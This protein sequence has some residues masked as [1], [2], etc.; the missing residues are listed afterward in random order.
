MDVTL[1][2]VLLTLE[3]YVSRPGT[4]VSND[5]IYATQEAGLSS[6][7]GLEDCISLVDQQ[8]RDLG[9]PQ[10]IQYDRLHSLDGLIVT[11]A[12]VRDPTSERTP[13]QLRIK[14]SPLGNAEPVALAVP[15]EQESKRLAQALEQDMLLGSALSDDSPSTDTEIQVIRCQREN[16]HLMVPVNVNIH[17]VEVKTAMLLD[18]GASVTVLSKSV[19]KR[20]L[21][22]HVTEL[23]TM[24]LT[25]GNG[26]V[27]CPVD[28]LRVSTT[29]YARRIHVA[30]VDGSTSLLGANYF[31]DRRFTVDLDRE[32]IYV[33]P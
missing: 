5:K 27:T 9:P 11:M 28:T 13:I 14:P 25:T 6:A 20:G 19:Y 23:K 18:T 12:F 4:P 15:P 33:H 32:C 8:N 21:A 16:M 1:T 24:R 30:L 29:A 2:H 3:A 17:G 31:A 26:P 7:K 10:A 22:R